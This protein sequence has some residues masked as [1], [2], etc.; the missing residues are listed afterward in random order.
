MSF[1][2]KLSEQDLEFAAQIAQQ[3]NASQRAAGRPDGL[4]KGSSIGRDVQGAQAE[5]AVSKILNLPWDGTWLPIAVWDKWKHEGTDVSGLEI[6]STTLATGRL[7]LHH[8]DKDH[9]PYVLVISSPASEFQLMG[10][11]Y[12]IDGKQAKYWRTN[13]PRPCYMVPQSELKTVDS[14]VEILK[15]QTGE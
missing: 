9:A 12:G 6:R 13:V 4:V 7:I 15:I 5:L 14:L 11:C 10:W 2:I 3:R 8:S 1:T